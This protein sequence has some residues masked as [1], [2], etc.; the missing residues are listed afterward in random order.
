ML[1]DNGP[2]D[3]AMVREMS[4]QLL[5]RGVI[6]VHLMVGVHGA[7]NI[8][9]IELLYSSMDECLGEFSEVLRTIVK[10]LR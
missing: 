4:Q 6:V 9:P 8:Y 5:A 7:P 3:I 1:C 2:D 10:N